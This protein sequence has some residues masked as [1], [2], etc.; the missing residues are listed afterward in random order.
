MIVFRHARSQGIRAIAVNEAALSREEGEQGLR[1]HDHGCVLGWTDD[2][3]LNAEGR[4]KEKAMYVRLADND[5]SNLRK[6]LAY[7]LGKQ[8]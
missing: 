6:A 4:T 2:F 3:Q 5:R 7:F 1:D 8:A